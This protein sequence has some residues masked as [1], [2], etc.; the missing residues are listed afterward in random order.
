M[1]MAPSP[2]IVSRLKGHRAELNTGTERSSPIAR[3][4]SYPQRP[5]IQIVTVGWIRRSSAR[6]RGTDG[7]HEGAWPAE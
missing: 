6:S 1:M 3:P 7:R 2:V 4:P 5:S